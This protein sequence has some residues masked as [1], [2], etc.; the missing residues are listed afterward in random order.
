MYHARH[1]LQGQ[2]VGGNVP[3]ASATSPLCI[4]S[5]AQHHSRLHQLHGTTVNSPTALLYALAHGLIWAVSLFP[6]KTRMGSSS[7]ASDPRL[8]IAS[9]RVALLNIGL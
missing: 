1:Q 2:T 3:Q 9:D 7:Q 6:A 4:H 5:S 8:R